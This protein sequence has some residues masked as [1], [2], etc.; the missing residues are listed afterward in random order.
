MPDRPPGPSLR[1]WST[2]RF[3]RYP[4]TVI[5]EWFARYGDPLYVPAVNGDV[6]MTAQPALVKQIFSTPASSYGP[7]AAAGV[8]ALTG[9]RSVFQL[10]DQEHRRHRRLIM[11]SFHGSRMRAYAADMQRAARHV[12]DGAVGRGPVP[13]HTLTQR[14]S[15]EVILRTVFGVQEPARVDRF[16]DAIT[17]MVEAISP[18]FIF[19]PFLQRELWGLSPYA[20]FRRRF[21]QLDALLVE[22]VERARQAEGGEDILSMLLTAR[23]EE[24]DRLDD[25]EIRDELRTLLFAGHETTGIALCW[26]VDAVG[27]RRPVAE[28]LADELAALGPEPEPEALAKVPYLEAVCNETLRRYPIVTEVLRTLHEPMELGGYALRPPTAVAACILGV[29][30]REDLYPEPDAFRPERFLERKFGPHE[31]LP[32]GGGHRRCIGAAFAGFEL[33]IVL[34]TLLRE[35]DVRLQSPAPP[36]PVRRNVTMA[37]DDGVPVVV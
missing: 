19:M 27:R 32:F 16:S 4:M 23:D 33:Q 35:Y 20:R 26:A 34:G 37:P 30:Q 29:H 10:R 6:V 15:L 1:L 5:P 11:P 28:R 3:L 22:Q 13:L 36:R 25:Q 31:F 18:M 9:P 12:F 21:E 7:F 17:E 24:G 2:F 8:A 14:I